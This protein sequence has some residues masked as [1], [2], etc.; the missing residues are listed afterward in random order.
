MTILS[1]GLQ[2]NVKAGHWNMNQIHLSSAYLIPQESPFLSM[3]LTIIIIIC[4]SSYFFS[5]LVS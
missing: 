2:W 3:I 4:S 1:A 5:D